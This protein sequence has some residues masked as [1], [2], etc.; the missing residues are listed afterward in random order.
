MVSRI[1]VERINM[2]EKD[3]KINNEMGLHIRPSQPA[4]KTPLLLSQM[5]KKN[6]KQLKY[7]QN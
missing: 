7:C 6:K 5:E 2:I 4:M 1:N 3:V